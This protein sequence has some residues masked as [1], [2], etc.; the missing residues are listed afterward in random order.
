MCD[1]IR[2]DNHDTRIS[3]SEVGDYVYCRRCWYFR[4]RGLLPPKGETPAMLRGTAQHTHLSG[5]LEHHA[6]IR[7]ILLM[8]IVLAAVICFAVLVLGVILH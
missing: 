8:V 6:T 4:L 1:N 7:T 5:E 3:A 2:M